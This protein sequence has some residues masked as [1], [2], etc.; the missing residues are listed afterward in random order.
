MVLNK[1]VLEY[2]SIAYLYIP[3]TLFL[4]GWI[5]WW[6]ALICSIILGYCIINMAMSFS[7]KESKEPIRIKIG[8][9][10]IAIVFFLFIGYFAGWGRW[11]AQAFD[12]FKHNAILKDL[13]IKSWP[14]YYKN[15]SDKS[16][17][18]YYIAQYLVPATL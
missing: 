12:W 2:I 17:L 1:K 5:K 9:L 6:I 13:T 15:G 16:M 3:I 7:E 11:V 4:F 18:T 14:V 8:I 10:I